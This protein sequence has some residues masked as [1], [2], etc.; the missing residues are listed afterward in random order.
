MESIKRFQ[1]RGLAGQVERVVIGGRTVDYWGP[2][3]GSDQIL[4]AHDG[5]NIF[6]RRTATFVYTWKLAQSAVRIAAEVGKRPPLVIGVFHSSTKED[7]HGRAKDLCPEDPFRDGVKPFVTPSIQI[8]QLRGNSYLGKIF[9]EILPA[10][11]A[12][13]HSH[14]SA[15]QTAM[16]GSSMGGLATLYAA[17]RHPEQFTTALA[18]STHWPLG[19]NPLVEW[20]LPRISREKISKVWMSRGTKGLDAS[21]PP[22]QDHA[23][24]MMTNLGWN[25][26]NFISKV[27]HRTTHNERSWASYVDEPLR[28]WLNT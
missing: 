10:I 11:V 18:L 19:G 6:D 1:V 22:F 8:D 7:P 23:D 20:M 9:E 14:Y 4:I 24:R 2:V 25:S 27:F 15:D 3:G 12:K 26:S 17:G 5:Q 21:Y 16:I 28:F 13:T